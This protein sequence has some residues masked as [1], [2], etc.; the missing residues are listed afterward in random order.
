MKKKLGKILWSLSNLYSMYRHHPLKYFRYL[1]SKV[2]T[3][4]SLTRGI[5]CGGFYFVAPSCYTL[6]SVTVFIMSH[7]DILINKWYNHEFSSGPYTWDD[8]NSFARSFKTA[9]KHVC[10]ELGAELVSFNKGHYYVSGFIQRW[11]KFIYFSSSDVR[12]GYEGWILWW[13]SVLIRTAENSRDFK[14]G[15]N[16]YTNLTEFQ[17]NVDLL[18]QR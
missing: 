6:T 15:A 4:I 8:F 17:E 14:G 11:S 16:N 9:M 1:N 7:F 10:H 12:S 2:S 13:G 18:L 5:F 3:R